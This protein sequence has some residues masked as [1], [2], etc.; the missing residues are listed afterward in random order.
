MPFALNADELPEAA[1]ACARSAFCN[2]MFVSLNLSNRVGCTHS[3]HL[4]GHSDV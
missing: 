1:V 2:A 4:R 3:S